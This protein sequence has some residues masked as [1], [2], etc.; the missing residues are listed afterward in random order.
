MVVPPGP[1]PSAHPIWDA[2]GAGL[3]AVSLDIMHCSH[4]GTLSELLGSLLWTFVYDDRLQGNATARL[5]LVWARVRDLY[6]EKKV[7]CRLV[8]L[9]LSMFTDP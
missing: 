6:R 2:P 3:F 4:L 8:N 5:A 9:T 1:R 7:D